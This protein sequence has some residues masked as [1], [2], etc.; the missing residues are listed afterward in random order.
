MIPLEDFLW[1]VQEAL[2]Q[3][4]RRNY[5]EHAMYCKGKYLLVQGEAPILLLAHLDTVHKEPVQVIRKKKGGNILTSPQGIGG[6]DR[7]GVYALAN[8]HEQAAR[9]PWLLF[10][11]DEEIGGVGAEVFAD[12]YQKK[13][14]PKAL[15]EVKM[16]VELDRKG[17]QDAVYYGCAN[18]DFEKYITSK[19]FR[20]EFGSFSD[21]SVV[22]P[23][24][25]IAAVNLSI[26]YYHA[27]TTSEYINRRHTDAVIEKV[28]G[29]VAESARQDVPQYEY[30]GCHMGFYGWDCY[31]MREG[32]RWHY[33]KLPKDLPKKYEEVYDILLDYFAMEELELY[34][35]EYGDEILLD[36]YV[37]VF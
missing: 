37:S 10:T 22:A 7:C 15:D 9:K 3:K 26:G 23:A 21:I 25:G 4:L 27:H 8:I 33:A 32:Y 11:C 13:Q 36:L 35:K 31:P 16:L 30:I 29:I 18:E 19:G 20:T 2:F 6:D 12:A 24:M 1:P 5:R 34:R 17:S 28:S 14:F